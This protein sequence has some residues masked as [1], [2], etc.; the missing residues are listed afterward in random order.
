M[1]RY[2]STYCRGRLE[3]SGLP[4]LSGPQAVGEG[5]IPE[6]IANLFR[7]D[8]RLETVA[9]ELAFDDGQSSSVVYRRMKDQDGPKYSEQEQSI[10]AWLGYWRDKMPAEAVANL[11]DILHVPEAS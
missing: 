11:Q 9:V 4:T 3:I 1:E 6:N 5:G 10:L 7:A 8:K 2:H